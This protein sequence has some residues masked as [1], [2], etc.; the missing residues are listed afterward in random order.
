[1]GPLRVLSLLRRPGLFVSL[2]V[3]GSAV[4]VALVAVEAASGPGPE[5]LALGSEVAFAPVEALEPADETLPAV[6]LPEPPPLSEPRDSDPVPVFPDLPPEPAGESAPVLG[7][8]GPG[9]AVVGLRAAP[10]KPASSAPAAAPVREAPGDGGVA[11]GPRRWAPSVARPGNEPPDYPSDAAARGE[12]GDV[13][14]LLVVGTD[15]AVVSATAESSSGHA[16]LDAA[17][18][19]AARTWRY[20]PARR[21]GVPVT[22]SLRV[23]FRFR[24]R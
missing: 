9:I 14:L 7:S 22:E 24:L 8:A 11:A 3:H 20:A 10:G 6:D 4:A 23:P 2:A 17:A 15:G 13:V 5:D 18:L 19:R 1:M 12:E 16:A 21:D